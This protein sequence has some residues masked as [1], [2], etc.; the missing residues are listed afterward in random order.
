MEYKLQNGIEKR[1]CTL[2]LHVTL[3]FSFSTCSRHLKVSMI[4]QTNLTIDFP[5]IVK[6]RNSFRIKLK[7]MAPPHIQYLCL[8]LCRECPYFFCSLDLETQLVET[9]FPS[10]IIICIKLFPKV[11][12]IQHLN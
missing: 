6:G 9:Y 8:F 4:L 5:S 7:A 1:H 12:L 3:L 10:L 11:D 2:V